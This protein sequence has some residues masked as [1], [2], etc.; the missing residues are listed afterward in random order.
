MRTQG[1]WKAR[2]ACERTIRRLRRNMLHGTSL[3]NFLLNSISNVWTCENQRKKNNTETDLCIK[4]HKFHSKLRHTVSVYQSSW[5][6]QWMGN[7][8]KNH[9]DG[10]IL[11]ERMRCV[12]SVSSIRA[13]S[14]RFYPKRLTSVNTHIDGRV[15]HARRQPAR[16]E[17]LG[18]S[19]SLRESS[20]LSYKTALPPELSWPVLLLNQINQ[21]TYYLLLLKIVT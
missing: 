21:I 3:Y 5:V 16:Q 17:Q 18:L 13:F 4:P 11:R 12:S 20:T 8:E 6:T 10:L 15:N 14:R 1:F 2:I 7:N 19:V 9:R